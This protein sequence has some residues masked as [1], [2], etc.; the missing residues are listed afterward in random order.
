MNHIIYLG[1]EIGFK[2]LEEE[3]RGR[4]A[5]AKHVE[6]TTH[7]VSEALREANALLDAS[8]KIRITNKMIQKADN[9]QIISCAT[10]GSDHIERE[11]LDRRSIPVRTLKDDQELLMGLTPAAE[12]SW[13]LLMACARRLTSAFDHVKDGK[14]TR[15]FFPGIMMKGKRLGI[16][17]CGRIGGWMGRYASS[18]G[19]EVA[20]YDPYIDP[21]PEGFI[22]AS[23]EELFKTCDFITVHVHLTE[24]T[25]GLVS[26]ELLESARNC[27]V[28]VNTSRGP[29]VDESALRE[30]LESGHVGAAAKGRSRGARCSRDTS[31]SH[32]TP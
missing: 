8:M 32:G 31:G 26:R 20:G 29:V 13:A 3:I 2:A 10:T 9:L 19:M 14:W 25:K 24:E 16:I 30:L 17:G 4:K 1:A 18:F 28:F 7:S 15:E 21:L 6:A 11:E 23:L 12:L 27:A 5:V 22:P